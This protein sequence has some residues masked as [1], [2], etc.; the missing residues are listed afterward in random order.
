VLKR[1]TLVFLF[2]HFVGMCVLS[3][4]YTLTEKVVVNFGVSEV[5]KE[6]RVRCQ[7]VQVK[8]FSRVGWSVG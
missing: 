5:L 6:W 8:E 1:R 7:V 4:N 3:H 2:R